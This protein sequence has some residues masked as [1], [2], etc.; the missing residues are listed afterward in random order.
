MLLMLI[1]MMLMVQPSYHHWH[2]QPCCSAQQPVCEQ[3]LVSQAYHP[4]QGQLS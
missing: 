1:L 2:C 4:S 3:G